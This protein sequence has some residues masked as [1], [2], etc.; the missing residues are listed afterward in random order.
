MGVERATTL[1]PSLHFGR[2]FGVQPDGKQVFLT[3]TGKLV[4]PHGECS[5]TICFWLA[6]EK[7]AREAGLPPP[8]RGGSRG[9]SACDCQTTEGLNVKVDAS[10][11]APPTAPDSLFDFLEAA[12]A[13][14]VTVKGRDARRVPH[15]PGPTFV[16][17]AG[18]LCCRHG[19]SRRSLIKR[20]RSSAPSAR[21]PTCKCVLAPLPL[22][23]GFKGV[24]LGKFEKKAIL[25]PSRAKNA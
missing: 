13:E 5:S 3:S 12:G 11:V 4:C 2:L 17:A 8:P 15:L 21:L 20:Q 22:R 23:A 19:A 25:A 14:L 18:R 1:L 7:K 16:T 10:V 9:S 24:R 6:A